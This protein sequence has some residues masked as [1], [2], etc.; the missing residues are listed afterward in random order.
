MDFPHRPRAS[1][2]LLGLSASPLQMIWIYGHLKSNVVLAAQMDPIPL[3]EYWLDRYCHELL[4]HSQVHF[5]HLSSGLSQTLRIV[6]DDGPDLLLATPVAATAAQFLQAQRI[7]LGWNQAIGL[8]QHGLPVP[9]DAPLRSGT[10]ELCLQSGHSERP[11]PHDQYIIL[12]K[13]QQNYHTLLLQ[14][15]QFLFEALSTIGIHHVKFLV[16]EHGKIYGADYRIWR[17]LRLITLDPAF[18]PPQLTTNF[19]ATGNPESLFGLNDQQIWHVLQCL[20]CSMDSRGLCIIHPCTAS[21]LLGDLPWNLDDGKYQRISGLLDCNRVLCIFASA[22]HWAFLGG[23]VHAHHMQ[24]TYSDGLSDALLPAAWTLAHILSV[25]LGF[26]ALTFEV[27]SSLSQSAPHTC[28]TIALLHACRYLDFHGLVT[29]EMI[30]GL[31]SHFQSLIPSSSTVPRAIGLGPQTVDSQLAALLVTK[32]VPWTAV[33]ERASAAVQK[34]GQTAVQGALQQANPWAALK[35]LTTKPGKHFQF[36]NKDELQTYVAQKAADKHGSQISSR[37]K[38]ARKP[39]GKPEQLHFDPSALSLL[40]GHFVDPDHDGVEQ[41]TLPQVTADARGVAICDLAQAL[42][43]I[44][45]A[46]RISSDALALLIT[47]EI[48]DEFRAQVDQ[49]TLRFP[50]TYLPTGDP[51]LIHGALLQLGDIPVHRKAMEEPSGDMEISTTTVIKLQVYR[52]ELVMDWDR[53]TES[54]IKHVISLVPK[55]RLC[56]DPRCDLRCAHFHPALED[57]LDQVIHEIWARRFQSLEGKVQPADKAVSFQAFLRVAAVALEELL[58]QTTEGIYLEPRSEATKATDTDFAVVWIPG[59]TRESALHKLKITPHGLGLVRL[60][61]RFGIRVRA[62]HEETVYLDLRPNESFVK[63]NINKIWRLH[64]LP[65]GLSRSQIAT[66]LAEW[67][68][69]AKPLQ[70]SRG[71]ADGGAWEVG[72]STTPPQPV[73]PA[74]NRDVLIHLLKDKTQQEKP[75]SVIA[76]RRAQAHQRTQQQAPATGSADPWLAPQHDPWSK[77][78]P[79]G[80]ATQ[81]KHYDVLAKK[82]KDDLTA[83]FQNQLQPSATASASSS[84]GL[85]QR[86]QQMEVGL[87]ELKAHNNQVGSWMKEAGARMAAQDDQLCQVTAGLKQQQAELV[88]VRSEVHSSAATLHQAMQTSFSTMKQDIVSDL[89]SSLD[90]QMSRF[91]TLLTAKKA[92]QE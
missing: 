37:K 68:W 11:L 17:A 10:Y 22:G 7:I 77:F 36:V 84:A 26:R 74:F 76:P 3:P 72:S 20:G 71:T 47:Q 89:A 2:A 6:Q 8:T 64:P 30:L 9:L 29:D 39:A 16:D 79:T 65:H 92:R 41:I 58:P 14:G 44:K 54:P 86:V 59:A 19:Q 61:Q 49:C 34:L 69:A 35:G 24:W 45:E 81:P 13:H 53:F 60:K 25:Q 85:E 80:S 28:G 88:A 1:L 50:V 31:H 15:G 57:T 42:P 62:Q 5:H 63:T 18:W 87:T 78:V 91:E 27:S 73:L 67:G 46:K 4:R 38:Q 12:I 70:P 40:P 55:F 21:I 90:S 75:S 43:Y 82:L 32:G 52:D 51:L 23:T 83:T 56:P 33:A 66:L 48:P